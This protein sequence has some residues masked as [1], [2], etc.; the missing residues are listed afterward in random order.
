MKS[1]NLNIAGYV[2]KFESTPDGP[3]LIPAQRFLRYIYDG[4]DYNVLIRVHSGN[5]IPPAEARKVFDAPYIEEING[6]RIKKNDKF[7]SVLKHNNDL[8]IQT[9]FP[10]SSENVSGT[11]KYSLKSREWDLWLEGAG[12]AADPM[13]YPIDS[14]IIYYLTVIHGDIMIHAAGVNNNGSGYVFSGVSGRGKSTIAGIFDGSGAM[15]IHDDRLIL[16]HTERGYFMYNTPVYQNDKPAES[17]VNRIFL[18]DHG[19]KNEL[20]PVE[21]ASAISM[22]IANCIQHNWDPEIIS[23]LLG[24]V[25]AMCTKIPVT[26][27]LFKP[28]RSIIDY[29]LHNE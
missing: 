22:V 2:I 11:L 7:W 8:F 13:E 5:I 1:Y 3:E 26:R 23:G 16:R 20:I 24:S 27:L 9:T 14:L 25:S 21:G 10:Y 12:K 18:I 28:D 19:T 6:L 15:V 17:P 4:A 29:L